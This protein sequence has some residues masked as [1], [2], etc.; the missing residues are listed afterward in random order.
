MPSLL[1]DGE[2]GCKSAADD[3]DGLAASIMTGGDGRRSMATRNQGIIFARSYRQYFEVNRAP[4]GAISGRGEVHPRAATEQARPAES[5][6]VPTEK[7]NR[8]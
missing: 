4:P 8:R 2:S 7:A 1:Q 6:A 5:G 3:F